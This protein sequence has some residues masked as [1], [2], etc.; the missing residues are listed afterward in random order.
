M[1]AYPAAIVT[2][3]LAF[4]RSKLATIPVVVALAEGSVFNTSATS[5]DLLEY[6]DNVA[7]P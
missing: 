5:A 1:A 6:V 7:T 2:Q 3:T 4:V